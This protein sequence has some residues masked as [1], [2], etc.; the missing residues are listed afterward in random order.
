MSLAEEWWPSGIVEEGERV[1]YEDAL[2]RP[3]EGVMRPMP[4][5]G[6]RARGVS[7]SHGALLDLHTG[8]AERPSRREV[9]NDTPFDDDAI[10]ASTQLTRATAV[11]VSTVI[12][13]NRTGTQL[14]PEKEDARGDLYHGYN[15]RA[16]AAP[17]LPPT[18]RA[19]QGALEVR[20]IGRSLATARPVDAGALAAPLRSDD[21]DATSTHHAGASTHA[22]PPVVPRAAP[23]RAAGQVD[24]AGAAGRSLAGATHAASARAA[25]ALGGADAWRTQRDGLASG[26][27]AR[28]AGAS[29]PTLSASDAHDVPVPNARATYGSWSAAAA[30][31]TWH[32]RRVRRAR[33][34]QDQLCADRGGDRARLGA[35][36]LL[37]G[38]PAGRAARVARPTSAPMARATSAATRACPSGWWPCTSTWR[39]C[40]AGGAAA[41][42]RRAR[43]ARTRSRR[44]PRRPP[45][46]TRRRRW[47]RA[48]RTTS[49]TPRAAR[50]GG[51]GGHGARLARRAGVGARRVVAARGWRAVGAARGARGQRAARARGRRRVARGRAAADG[52]R[53]R[54]RARRHD[55]V[56]GCARSRRGRA[57]AA[58]ATRRAPR[59]A[60]LVHRGL[61]Q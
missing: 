54:R 26:D 31:V 29:A 15:V 23:A 56:A 8:T 57:R 55:R 60:Q 19:A 37:R 2:G 49:A 24:L 27:V 13:G 40:C 28:R 30:A 21:L 36:R 4:D 43:A 3:R 45:P 11:R 50:R 35:R 18:R 10:S 17:P 7:M 48:T 61:R 20:G 38:G 16:R 34:V 46:C 14:A 42:A 1:T 41:V 22:A 59:R 5:P 44:P 33:P 12:H 58:C 6:T 51:G 52:R 53:R 9:E 47:R 39:A 25:L 32:A